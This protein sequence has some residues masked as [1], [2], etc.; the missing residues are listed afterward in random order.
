VVVDTEDVAGV[1]DGTSPG[2]LVSVCTVTGPVVKSILIL[3]P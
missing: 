2:L 1:I 3:I